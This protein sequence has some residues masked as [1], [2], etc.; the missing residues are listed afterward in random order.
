MARANT[1][2][3]QLFQTFITLY[4]YIKKDIYPYIRLGGSESLEQ[5]EQKSG[6][7]WYYWARPVPD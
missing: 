5:L 2:L 6:N 1:F 4:V 7:V 3:F